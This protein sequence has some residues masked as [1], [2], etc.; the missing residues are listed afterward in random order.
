MN[1]DRDIRPD[2]EIERSVSTW[3][4]DSDLPTDEAEQGLHRLLQT[5]P[6]TPQTRR[7]FLGRWLERDKGAR[8]RTRTRDHPALSS[9]RRNRLMFSSTGALATLAI[10][11]VGLIVV[12]TQPAQHDAS[13]GIAYTV[14][15]TGAGDFDTIQAAVDAATD[16]DT[17]MVKPGTY[18]EAV[19]IRKD[20]TLIGDGDPDEVTI[21]APENGPTAPI[22]QYAHIGSSD[23][24][25]AIL[26]DSAD[27]TL[28]G[29]TVRGE[30]SSVLARGGAPVFEGLRL[31]D[32]GRTR[33]ASESGL[34]GMIVTGGSR[35]IVRSNELTGGGGLGITDGSNPL[36]EGNTLTDGPHI[37]GNPGM[38]AVIRGN[39]IT[40]T[41][42]DGIGIFGP[43]PTAVSVEGNTIRP[44]A[45]NG[46][47]IGYG[48]SEGVDPIIL[49]NTLDGGGTN[50]GTA[51]IIVAGLDAAPIIEGNLLTGFRQGL[52][53]SPRTPARVLDND[54]TG[55][56][57]GITVE[58]DARIERNHVRENG[59]ALLIVGGAP[60]IVENVI[61]DNDTAVTIGSGIAA[62]APAF[63]ANTICGNKADVVATD[64]DSVTGLSSSKP[65]TDLTSG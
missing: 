44:A 64:P 15:A 51:G 48:A 17:I 11:A 50:K 62:A 38:E 42:N 24:P 29:L 18:V 60:Q 37:Y 23:I 10:F 55:N 12:D 2:L 63:E 57:V 16:G 14:D 21:T 9:D 65:C 35:A 47:S 56:E 6:T 4:I 7:R 22:G 45:G 36:I 59:T 25:F 49:S 33:G 53:L 26:I 41:M 19:V 32:V 58:A 31:V 27:A 43:E 13:A 20:L 8:R 28:A 54:V 1:H 3:L 52:V 34:A 61:E 39:T 40:G 46:I 5:F 30:A